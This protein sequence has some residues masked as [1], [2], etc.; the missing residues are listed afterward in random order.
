MSDSDGTGVIAGCLAGFLTLAGATRA[1]GRGATR[2]ATA[3]V[4]YADDVAMLGRA[5]HA[6]EAGATPLSRTRALGAGLGGLDDEARAWSRV[7]PAMEEGLHPLASPRAGIERQLTDLGHDVA[8]EGLKEAVQSLADAGRPSSGSLARE[9]GRAGPRDEPATPRHEATLLRLTEASGAARFQNA[10]DL[11]VSFWRAE[12]PVA[13]VVRETVRGRIQFTNGTNEP[14]ASALAACSRAGRVCVALACDLAAS[15]CYD[16]AVRAWGAVGP[17]VGGA[18][19]SMAARE[20]DA[21]LA[22]VSER[23]KHSSTYT[24]SRV[25][26]TGKLFES[27]AP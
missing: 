21:H 9:A 12:G 2:V 6:L 15:A 20:A 22:L 5:G 10:S 14:L 11:R 4:R 7:T 18:R 8:S 24:L 13:L 23:A 26:P 3:G 17:S 25:G 19:G 16:D 1:C 27:V